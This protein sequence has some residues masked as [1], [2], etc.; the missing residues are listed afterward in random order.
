MNLDI[1][2]ALTEEASPV[3]TAKPCKIGRWLQTIPDDQP[4]KTDL[5]ATLSTNDPTAAHYRTLATLDR[6]LI[7]LGASASDKTIQLH[8]AGDCRCNA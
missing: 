8:R 6:L 3:G 1:L 2:S 7:K 4:G 5:V